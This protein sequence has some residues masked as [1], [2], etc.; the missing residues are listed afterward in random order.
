MTETH[1]AKYKFKEH[2]LN[3]SENKNNY[4]IALK[5]WRQMPDLCNKLHKGSCKCICQHKLKYFYI[6]SN[7]KTHKNINVGKECYKK[8]N[9]DNINRDIN[10][11]YKYIINKY[12]KGEYDNIDDV[13]DFSINVDKHIEQDIKDIY[14]LNMTNII[15]LNYLKTNIIELIEDYNFTCLEELKNLIIQTIIVLEQKK[16]KEEKIKQK[17][18]EERKLIQEEELKLDKKLTHEKQF[19]RDCVCGLSKVCKCNNPEY[20][21]VK[22]NKQ[23]ICK[24]CENWKCRCI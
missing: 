15:K 23:F 1:D 14:K 19:L 11:I 13:D 18:E 3:L 21:I 5:E 6:I 24:N 12:F 20:I 17:I 4:E 8:F 16:F 9:F 2:I 22:L 7:K 10:E